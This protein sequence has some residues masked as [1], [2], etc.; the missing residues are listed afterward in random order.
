MMPCMLNM[1]LYAGG[2]RVKEHYPSATLQSTLEAR[3]ISMEMV[4]AMINKIAIV[5][6]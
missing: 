2:R 6:I 3:L 1:G 4:I 5:N